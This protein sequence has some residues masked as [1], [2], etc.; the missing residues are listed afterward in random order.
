MLKRFL[1][2]L[3]V[4]LP[5]LLFAQKHSISASGGY[6][7][8]EGFHLFAAYQYTENLSLGIGAGSHFGLAPLQDDRHYNIWIENRL[9]FGSPARLAVKPWIF[10]QQ[11]MYWIQGSGPLTWQILS[12]SPTI[13]R[14]FGLTGSLGLAVE[15]GPALNWVMDVERESP[16]DEISGW[17]WPVLPNGRVQ[18]VYFF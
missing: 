11:F 5:A 6:G 16:T 18:L 1:V 13:G 7:Y 3:L 17:M 15:I 14:M 2:I 12:F 9:H 10:G 8:Y 4:S